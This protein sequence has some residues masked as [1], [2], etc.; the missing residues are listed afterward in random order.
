MEDAVDQFR[1]L[2]EYVD[3]TL[4]DGERIMVE[5]AMPAAN[6]TLGVQLRIDGAAYGAPLEIPNRQ[7]A[8]AIEESVG[9]RKGLVHRYLNRYR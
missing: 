8:V 3:E 6:E 9:S 7:S 4:F 5:I 2:L 1:A